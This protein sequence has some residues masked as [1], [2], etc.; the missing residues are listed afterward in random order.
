M[1]VGGGGCMPYQGGE[2]GEGGGGK[3]RDS[4]SWESKQ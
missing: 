3:K 4:L 1:Q 2:G